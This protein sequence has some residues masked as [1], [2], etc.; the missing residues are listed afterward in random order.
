MFPYYSITHDRKDA[1][2]SSIFYGF[3]VSSLFVRNTTMS[4]L[5]LW[6]LSQS[7]PTLMNSSSIL[8]SGLP[9][10]QCWPVIGRWQIV[11]FFRS[12]TL[13]MMPPTSVLFCISGIATGNETSINYDVLGDSLALFGTIIS[14]LNW[15]TRSLPT[16]ALF[17]VI[18]EALI[19]CRNSHKIWYFMSPLLQGLGRLSPVFHLPKRKFCR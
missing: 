7:F 6:F 18:I 12:T 16:E 4:F 13:S 14:S 10:P 17:L 3:L 5:L 19:V 8:D 1:Y 9:A 11:V 2:K 15:Y